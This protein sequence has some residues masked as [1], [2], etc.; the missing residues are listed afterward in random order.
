MENDRTGT[1]GSAYDYIKSKRDFL[2]HRYGNR[3]PTEEELSALI[4]IDRHTVRRALRKLV[5]DGY[6]FSI[7]NRGY[8]HELACDQVP[9]ESLSTYHRYCEANHL[10][11]RMEILGLSIDAGWGTP[12]KELGLLKHEEV[13]NI[14]FLRYRDQLPFSLTRSWLPR[15]HTPGLMALVRESRS[16]HHTLRKNYGI[17]AAR[18]KTVCSAVNAPAEE[19]RWLGLP[20][21]SAL[22][23]SASTAVDQDGRP[24]EYCE[25]L[26]RGDVVKLEFRFSRSAE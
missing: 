18:I 9:V 16:L 20:Q 23:K 12:A 1:G 3:L 21:G 24:I 6:L 26:F 14:L 8:F 13:W 25:T 19:S 5:V 17:N 10:E 4:G 22:L 11:P 2:K 7:R 15:A